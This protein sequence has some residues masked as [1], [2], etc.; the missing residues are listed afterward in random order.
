MEL[1]LKMCIVSFKVYKSLISQW[2]IICELCDNMYPYQFTNN[3]A[4]CK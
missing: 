4:Q 1:R 3:S 2:I